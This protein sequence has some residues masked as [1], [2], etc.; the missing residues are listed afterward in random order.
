[1]SKTWRERLGQIRATLKRN[2][3][4]YKAIYADPRT[5]RA[6]RWLLSMNTAWLSG[7]SPRSRCTAF[8]TIPSST[9]LSL[10]A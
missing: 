2:I 10:P 3:A 9:T 6:A 8:L 7:R 1:M 5:P 4:L